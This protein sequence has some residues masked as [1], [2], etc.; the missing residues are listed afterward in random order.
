MNTDTP[1]VTSADQGVFSEKMEWM[2]LGKTTEFAVD[3]V[4]TTQR[5]AA[6]NADPRT[7]RCIDNK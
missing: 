6:E 4:G 3:N 1:W 2:L 7:N 5:A